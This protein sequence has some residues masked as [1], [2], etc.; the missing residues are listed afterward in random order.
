MLITPPSGTS[1]L[2]A[3]RIGPGPEG[4]QP[5]RAQAGPRCPEAEPRVLAVIAAPPDV[6]LP[7]LFNVATVAQVARPLWEGMRHGE[8]SPTRPMESGPIER[9]EVAGSSGWQRATASR[10]E[11]GVSLPQLS[12][13]VR[14]SPCA[15]AW[16]GSAEDRPA[17][18]VVSFHDSPRAARTCRMRP[19]TPATSPYP[20]PLEVRRDLSR[21]QPDIAP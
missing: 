1:E 21:V 13:S 19:R 6:E 11:P 18:W 3:P 16:S 20:R 8:F 2:G 4:V 12:L 15:S 10:A 7:G 5:A 17:T 14:R 9:W